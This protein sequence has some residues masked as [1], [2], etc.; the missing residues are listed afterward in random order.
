M[1]DTEQSTDDY[2]QKVGVAL[3]ENIFLLV[4]IATAT[5]ET[6]HV[7]KKKCN[8]SGIWQ[9]TEVYNTPN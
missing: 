1:R 4:T 6:R 9:R 2:L 8:I 5:I 7:T 3:S